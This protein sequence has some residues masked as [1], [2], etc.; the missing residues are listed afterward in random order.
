VPS[1]LVTVLLAL[2]REL[3]FPKRRAVNFASSAV[4]GRRWVAVA[5][6]QQ[7]RFSQLG[8]LRT[9]KQPQDPIPPELECWVGADAYEQNE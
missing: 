9:E 1:S 3:C 5:K 2:V 6:R 8:R 7:A 4:D